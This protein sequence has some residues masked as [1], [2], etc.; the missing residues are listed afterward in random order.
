MNKT[1]SRTSNIT[2][3]VA[4]TVITQVFS[5]LFAFANRTI[6]I[7]LLGEQYL[8][9]DG[10]FTSLLTI[11]SLAE[12]GI[13]NALIFSLY[14]PIAIGDT[15]RAQQY[16]HLYDVAYRWIIGTIL[17]VGVLLLPFLPLLINNIEIESLG[18]NIY[19]VYLLFLFNTVSSYFFAH[20]QAVLVINQM[21]STVSLYQTATKIAVNIIEC[22]VLLIFSSYYLFLTIRVVGNYT[23]AI[24]ISYKAKKDYPELCVDNQTKLPKQDIDRIKQDVYA[25]F[26]RRVGGVVLASAD[27]IIIN[28]F[29]SLTMVGIY[30]NYVL[31]VNSVQGITTLM[32][33]AM[34]ASIGNFIATQTKNESEKAFE[35]YSYITYLLYGICSVCFILLV[36]RF[37]EI[38]WG[39]DYLLSKFALYLIVL[40][41]FLYGFQSAINTFRDT[42]GLFVQGKYRSCFSASVNIIFSILLVNQMG[43][44]GVILGTI[45]SRLLISVWYDPYILYKYFFK[46]SSVRYF[47]RLCL[48]LIIVFST[49]TFMDYITSSIPSTIWGFFGCLIISVCSIVCMVIPF[50]KSDVSKDLL[51]RIKMILFNFR[52]KQI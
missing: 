52:Q 10:L 44:E 7:Y 46:K 3:N 27:N 51:Y 40:N 9:I 11:F 50:Y 22:V 37:V 23:M 45:L 1:N 13:G 48:F 15:F 39:E 42:T 26:I 38:L 34:T 20:R 21:Q 35:L 29:I 6:F 8:G 14:K 16:L 30:S 28:A 19:I 5:L 33:T 32:M 17:L 18:I 24:L 31:I 25:L 36:N 12:L 49:C 43:I 2:R 4:V 47:G 41:F